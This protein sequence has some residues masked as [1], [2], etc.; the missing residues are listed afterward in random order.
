M[1]YF[2]FFMVII[3]NIEFLMFEDW[4]MIELY[5]SFLEDNLLF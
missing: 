3:V 4:E 5:G 2:D 1:I